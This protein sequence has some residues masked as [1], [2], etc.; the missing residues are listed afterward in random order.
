[1]QS[2]LKE[3]EIMYN[4]QRNRT[5]NA[6]SLKNFNREISSKQKQ[7]ENNSHQY[8]QTVNK[9]ISG[10]KEE[11]SNEDL[12]VQPSAIFKTPLD[13]TLNKPQI[14]LKESPTQS[15]EN[16]KIIKR[17]A[18]IQTATGISDDLFEDSI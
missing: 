8:F 16:S 5:E 9:N 14:T 3:M 13:D 2:D 6:Y 17:E 10:A 7:R 15:F 18:T 4:S 12:S 1:M 11:K